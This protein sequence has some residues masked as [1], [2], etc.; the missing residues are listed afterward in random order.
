MKKILVFLALALVAVVAVES[1][2]SYII[3]R[4]YAMGE[5]PLEPKGLA[6]V[7]LVVGG[8]NKVLGRHPTQ[9]VSIDHGYLF[10]ANEALGYALHPGR[11]R[12]HEA[13]SGKDHY[14]DLTVTEAGIRRTSEF[15]V[16]SDKRIFMIGDSTMFGWGLD[17]EE[18]VPW[19]IQAKLPHYQIFNFAL[20]S[21]SSVQA[22]SQLQ[23]VTPKVGSKDIVVVEY[24]PLLNELNVGSPGMLDSMKHGYELTL[25]D[26]GLRNAKLPFATIDD[27]GKLAI[28]RISFSCAIEPATPD[29]FRPAFDLPK[30]IQ[31][32]MRAFDEI[33]ASGQGH[34]V[35]VFLSGTDDDPVIERLRTQGAAIVDV[36]S[37]KAIPIESDVIAVDGH[38]G[39]FGQY[40]IAQ[41][42]YDSLRHDVIAE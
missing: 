4:Y 29:C 12:V 13:L 17:D 2:S 31:V 18:T 40:Q 38:L 34:L 16:H 10:E 39:P 28:Q 8:I 25:G 23:S 33:V 11:Y 42:L 19:L 22:L 36:R 14:F 15:P 41:R 35:V 1:I 30:A 27:H 24:H 37:G 9:S 3:F 32:T 7:M 5:K 26:A 21:Y 6:T 20:T